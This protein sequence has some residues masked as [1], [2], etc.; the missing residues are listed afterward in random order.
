MRIGA[1]DHPD[2]DLRRDR[3]GHEAGAR[4]EQSEV[5]AKDEDQARGTGLL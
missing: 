1:S 2:G 3:F 4:P 5:P